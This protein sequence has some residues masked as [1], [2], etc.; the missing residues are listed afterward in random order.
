M[1]ANDS[2][3]FFFFLMLELY[4]QVW[5][6]CPFNMFLSFLSFFGHLFCDKNKMFQAHL[7]LFLFS[8]GISNFL[9]E[10]WFLFAGKGMKFWVMDVSCPFPLCP[11]WELQ[12]PLGRKQMEGV[13]AS[14]EPRIRLDS[15]RLWGY[16]QLL[17][18]GD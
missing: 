10:P 13:R 11:S 5:F 9:Q 18:S 14:P 7:G 4:H 1:S 12:I 2:H 6:L 3:Y 15:Y 16:G 8:L 17:F